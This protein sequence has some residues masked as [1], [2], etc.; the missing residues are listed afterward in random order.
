MSS[1]RHWVLGSVIAALILLSPALAFL[2]VITAEMVIDVAMVV[3][4][5][6]ICAIAAG[7]IG[8]VLFR[9]MSPRRRLA[10]LPA[11]DVALGKPAIS[12]PPI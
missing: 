1:V 5:I 11:D 3:G 9:R 2:M 6:E 8:W 10:F 12:A 7:A 4:A